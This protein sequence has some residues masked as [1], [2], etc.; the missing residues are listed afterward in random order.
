MEQKYKILVNSGI[1]VYVY[2]IKRGEYGP[3]CLNMAKSLTFLSSSLLI[4]KHSV[5]V[6]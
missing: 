1:K 2:K 4:C 3:D 6:S 5:N